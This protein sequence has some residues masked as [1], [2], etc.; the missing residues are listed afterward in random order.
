MRIPDWITR[1]APLYGVAAA[2]TA[3]TALA[4]GW[5]ASDG[6]RWTM[7]AV[8]L[9]AAGLAGW[10]QRAALRG[11]DD[12]LRHA[13]EARRLGALALPPRHPLTR[14]LA[15]VSDWLGGTLA[16][17]AGHAERAFDTS[18]RL[19]SS[20]AEIAQLA[21][22]QAAVVEQAAGAG[23]ALAA[24][25]GEIARLGDDTHRHVAQVHQL[26][27]DGNR[28]VEGITEQMQR[29]AGAVGHSASHID[30]LA[31][32][33][34]KIGGIITVIRDIADQTNLLA[35]NAAI[36]AARAGENGRGFAVVA[37][38]V[39][40]LAERTTQATTEIQRT[41][42]A[43]Q[44]QTGV[45]VES[46]RQESEL[47]ENGVALAGQAR[48]ALQAIRHR[49]QSAADSVQSIASAAEQQRQA[50]AGLD[51]HLQ[52]ISGMAARFASSADA[53]RGASCQLLDQLYRGKLDAEA[54]GLVEPVSLGRLHQL[55][56]HL[57]AN[58]IL[59]VNSA[60][61][62]AIAPFVQAV[63]RHDREIDALLPALPLPPPARQAL[64]AALQAYRQARDPVLALAAAGRIDE[65][66]LAVASQ[67]RPAFRRLGEQLGECEATLAPS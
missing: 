35:L 20:A 38:E 26:A 61:G 32:H 56:D 65:A 12:E 59:A 63:E 21:E 18:A 60:G 31:A 53:A 6:L 8:P 55:V 24:A 54:N 42:A 19:T 9:V 62:A 43:M 4:L 23:S 10:R 39:R 40:K 11:I 17:F 41:I 57:R 64:S 45:A 33:A 28:Q 44:S 30:Q 47:V 66:V 27:D 25:I 29:M 16:V 46:M 36:E 22:R 1:E 7:A 34:D 51:Q 67:V 3:A 37:D 48:E 49:S 15:A 2:G 5:P 13:A 52:D 50:S 14:S 58:V